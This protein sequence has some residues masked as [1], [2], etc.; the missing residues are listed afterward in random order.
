MGLAIF[1]L[2]AK[3][4]RGRGPSP[5]QKAAQRAIM[6]QNIGTIGPGDDTSQE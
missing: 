3:T 2:R 1:Y 6:G 4:E 5:L